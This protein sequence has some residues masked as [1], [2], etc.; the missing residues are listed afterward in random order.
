[1][2][3]IMFIGGLVVIVL[4]VVAFGLLRTENRKESDAMN[5]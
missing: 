2:K 1:M 3:S 5:A 4:V